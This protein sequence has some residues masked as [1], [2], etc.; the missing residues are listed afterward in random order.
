[1]DSVCNYISINSHTILHKYQ[2]FSQNEK[3]DEHY[4][5]GNISITSHIL[6]NLI[7]LTDIIDIINIDNE[8]GLVIFKYSNTNR[9]GSI[10]EVKRDGIHYWL[11]NLFAI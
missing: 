6:N 2:Y 8:C 4:V 1:M 3:D 9:T 5:G 10:C 7:S 11:V